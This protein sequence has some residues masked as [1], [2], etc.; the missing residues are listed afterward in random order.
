[1]KFYQPRVKVARSLHEQ[2]DPTR[3]LMFLNPPRIFENPTAMELFLE[4]HPDLK[5]QH[6]Q[7]LDSLAAAAANAPKAPAGVAKRKVTNGTAAK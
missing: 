6:K 4:D 3:T 5:I 2:Y 7:W 1:M